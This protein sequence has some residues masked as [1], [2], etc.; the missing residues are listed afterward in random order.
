[1]LAASQLL[2]L[3]CSLLY[4]LKCSILFRVLLL[5]VASQISREL[6]EN[7]P[8]IAFSQT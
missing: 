8:G 7:L 6:V 1:M 3:L 5:D 2:G 4:L